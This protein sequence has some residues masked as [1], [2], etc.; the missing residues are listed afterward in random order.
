MCC[1]LPLKKNKKKTQHS[2]SFSKSH[3]DTRPSDKNN[4]MTLVL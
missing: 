1:V 4:K 2:T 3:R